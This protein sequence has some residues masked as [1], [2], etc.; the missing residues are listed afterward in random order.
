MA[1]IM[2]DEGE[3]EGSKYLGEGQHNCLITSVEA[4]ISKK[5]GAMV[6]V[7]FTAQNGRTT[8]DWFML[9]GNKFKLAS[10]ALAC[11]FTKTQLLAGQFNTVALQ[12]K[13]VKVVREI[14]GTDEQGRK[15]YENSYLPAEGGATMAAGNSQDIPF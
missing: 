7:G 2:F 13:G 15:N 6:E 5:G 4:K 14:K 8:R 12:G 10:L 3:L 1:Q 9:E 11:G